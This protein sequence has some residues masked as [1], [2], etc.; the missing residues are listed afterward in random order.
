M[1]NIKQSENSQKTSKISII[2]PCYNQTWLLERNLQYL[3]KQ[4]FK[5]FDITII[6]D[7]STENYQETISKFPNLKIIYIRNDKNLGAME[8]IFNS[9]FYKNDSLYKIALHEDDVLHPQYLEKAINILDTNEKVVFVATLAKW[10]R[11][12][13]EFK[14]KFVESKDISDNISIINKTDFIRKI[15][16]GKHIMWDSVVYR[17]N[18]LNKNYDLKK[19]DVLCDRPFLASLIGNNFV[20]IIEDKSVFVRDHGENDNRGKNTTEE[21]CFNMM[22]FY[23]D[24]LP[25]PISKND[26]KKFIIFSTNNLLNTYRGIRNKKMGFCK[27][28]K[29]GKNLGLIDLKYINKI[30]IFG[31]LKVIFGEKITRLIK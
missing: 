31:M 19:Y 13:E 24:S 1:F 3:E 22:N 17:N 12:D 15:L 30:G 26:Y 6:D 28:I 29:T 16:D 9:I 20:A 14:K 4:S 21:H 23:K 27:F 5:N 8:N 18:I 10:F 11:N 2:I 7:Q 25:K